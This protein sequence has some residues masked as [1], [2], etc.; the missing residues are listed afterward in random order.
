MHWS[1]VHLVYL[2]LEYFDDLDA[3][4]Q[5]KFPILCEYDAKTSR[6]KILALSEDLSQLWWYTFF[7]KI[8]KKMQVLGFGTSYKDGLCPKL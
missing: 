6:M 1:N 5:I 7:T 2:E 4:R 8:G 3:I